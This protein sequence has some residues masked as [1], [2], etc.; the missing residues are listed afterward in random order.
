[1]TKKLL[2]LFFLTSLIAQGQSIRLEGVVQDTLRKPLEMANVMAINQETKA[3]DSYGITNDK[4]RFQLNLKPNSN[5]KIKISYI[6]FQTL[7]V[8]IE[9]KTENFQKAFTLKEGDVNL[10]GVE[11][12]HEMPVSIKG[13][14]IIY[15][16][17]SFKTGTEK[18]LEDVLKKLPGVEVNADGEI[19]VEGKKVTQL[20]VDGKKF[21]EGDTKL[22]AKNIP[23]DAVDKVQVLRNYSEVS[24]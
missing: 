10:E 17:D 2:F 8:S 6:G 19:E 23:S 21:F 11:V 9:T 20:L 16:A 18:K 22:G 1:M 4:G 12:V 5:Y 14:T 15:N 3:M 24:Q 7:D 13:D